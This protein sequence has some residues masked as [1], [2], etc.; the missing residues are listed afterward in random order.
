MEHNLYY[1]NNELGEQTIA[2][3]RP[4]IPKWMN[5]I[6]LHTASGPDGLVYEQVET[7]EPKTGEVLV[8]VHAAAITR[9]E[10]TWPTDRLPAIPSYEFSGVVAA[11]GSEVEN[12]KVGEPV[13]ALSAFNRDGAAAD[14]G[15]VSKQFLAPKPESIDHIQSASIP[16]AALTAWQG[17]FEH[18]QLTKGQRVL[19]HGATGGVGNFA[20]QLARQCGAYVIGTVSTMHV[21]AA[22][23]LGVDQVIDYTTTRFEAV[24]GPVDLVFD[25]VGGD[26]LERSPS[27]VR[28]GGRLVSVATEPSQEQATA[29][30]IQ[31]LYFV[32]KPNGNQLAELT[33]LVDSGKLQPAI[34][35]VFPLV[36]AREAFERSLAAH[37]AGKI[38]LRIA[39]K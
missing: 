11:L 38:V 31:A 29:H 33:R 21:A 1:K 34:D 5:A 25:T 2:K 39:D 14:Y 13:Y 23:K 37:S 6:R 16:L 24:A 27:V 28:P 12:V 26:R 10:L 19:I 15:I 22:Q 9:D 7:P 18:G 4:G 17:L 32:V 20:V 8:R 35:Q 30:N 36:H 3:D